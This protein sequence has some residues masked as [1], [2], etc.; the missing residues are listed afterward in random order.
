MTSR[1]PSARPSSL[2]RRS[3]LGLASVAVGGLCIPRALATNDAGVR[4]LGDDLGALSPFEREHLPLVRLPPLTNNGGKVPIL[5]EMDHPMTPEHHITAVQ[6]T[7]RHDPVPSK[8]TFH[9][10]PANGRVY[11]SFQARIAA[12]VSEV[13]VTAECNRHGRWSTRR[14]IEIPDHAG[15]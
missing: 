2:S 10:T 4:M 11:V 8:G 3:F 1:A 9:L 14:A 6:V 12:G 5:V 13:V 15:G 7:N